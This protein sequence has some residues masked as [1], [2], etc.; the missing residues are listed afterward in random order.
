[1]YTLHWTI[2]GKP[3]NHETDNADKA[4]ILFDGLR[5]IKGIERVFLSDGTKQLAAYTLAGGLIAWSEN[6]QMMVSIPDA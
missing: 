4:R 1:M 5:W 3:N 6:L 2:K